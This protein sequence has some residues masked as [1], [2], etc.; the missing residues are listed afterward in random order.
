[1]KSIWI[2]AGGNIEN[3][4]QYN[5]TPSFLARSTFFYVQSFGHFFCDSKY[6]TRREGYKSFLMIYTL[7]GKGYAE[8]R[9]KKYELSKGQ[10]LIMD[11]FDYHEYRTDPV[12]LWEIKWVHFNGA[13]S[14]QYFNMIY[15][16]YGPVI[17]MGENECISEYMDQIFSMHKQDDKQIEIKASSIIVRMLTEILLTTT[18]KTLE[19]KTKSDIYDLQRVYDL[20]EKNYDSNI[21]LD[22]MAASVNLSKYYFIKVFKETTCY[23]PYEYLVKYRINRAKSLL[24]STD[25]PIEQIAVEVGFESTSNFIRTF[26]KIESMTPLRYRRYWRG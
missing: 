23:S 10:V 11:C 21:S 6:Y 16:K 8:Y 5:Y 18:G 9:G 20:I 14:E 15:E 13:S 4:Y 12:E 2:E 26:K 19:L 25:K 1:M 3:M 24:E 22:D 7:N 17:N